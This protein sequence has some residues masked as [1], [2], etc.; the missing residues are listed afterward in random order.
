LLLRQFKAFFA[1]S[2]IGLSV[3]A[4]LALVI[5]FLQSQSSSQTQIAQSL[6]T[7]QNFYQQNQ[8]RNS[9]EAKALEGEY[10]A[11][12]KLAQSDVRNIAASLQSL[13][14]KLESQ[15]EA[16]RRDWSAAIH[17][18]PDQSGEAS[19]EQTLELAEVTPD[20]ALLQLMRRQEA[21]DSASARLGE[22]NAAFYHFHNGLAGPDAELT[23]SQ[24]LALEGQIKTHP[25]SLLPA[26]SSTSFANAPELAAIRASMDRLSPLL[27]GPKSLRQLRERQQ[28]A[29]ARN[30]Q[31][32]EGF[33]AR[34]DSFLLQQRGTQ[35]SSWQQRASIAMGLLVLALGLGA[36]LFGRQILAGLRSVTEEQSQ[37]QEA[38]RDWESRHA[39]ALAALERR[40]QQCRQWV[41]RV[42]ERSEQI[43]GISQFLG[44]ATAAIRHHLDEIRSALLTQDEARAA[45]SDAALRLAASQAEIRQGAS[46]L[47]QIASQSRILSFNASVE[48]SRSAEGGAAFLVVADAMRQL[49]ERSSHTAAQ[50]EETF[51]RSQLEIAQVQDALQALNAPAALLSRASAHLADSVEQQSQKI[52]EISIA[53]Q[54]L[55]PASQRRGKRSNRVQRATLL[56]LVPAP[57][58]QVPVETEVAED[59]QTEGQSSEQS[60]VA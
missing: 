25:K 9:Q 29:V 5:P 7:E 48:A 27:Q 13:Q 43:G 2:V 58:P 20:P 17:R 46:G 18:V 36:M 54:A 16:L 10:A 57:E 59:E 19:K 4:G 22:A 23:I 42:A 51:E 33:L 50:M 12:L 45:L 28:E 60:M 38:L 31:Q 34:L 3:L 26:L 44:V 15:R 32:L 35:F 30:R 37:F 11:G 21:L 40:T 8:D 52:D 1:L 49:A 47:S 41:G 55:Q 56:T 14:R 24:L 53:A 6:H 39:E